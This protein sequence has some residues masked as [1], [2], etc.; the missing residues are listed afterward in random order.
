MVDMAV[1]CFKRSSA[2]VEEVEAKHP[3]NR[4]H[5]FVT[6]SNRTLPRSRRTCSWNGSNRARSPT[7]T[8]IPPPQV[9]IFYGLKGT[10]VCELVSPDQ[11]ISERYTI[12]TGDSVY[13]P[14]N[15]THKIKNASEDAEWVVLGVVFNA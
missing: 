1:K 15:W 2:E 7:R 8:I 3:F 11:S 5:F 4:R 14:E 10:G 12:A 9:E 13:C 6:S